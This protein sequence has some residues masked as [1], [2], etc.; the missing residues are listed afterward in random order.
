[1]AN[2]WKFGIL[3][4]GY[5]FSLYLKVLALRNQML[6]CGRP[7]RELP[8]CFYSD[9]PEMENL[10]GAASCG[11]KLRNSKVWTLET[12][13]V[14]Y[15]DKWGHILIQ[16]GATSYDLFTKI[17]I[18]I[19]GYNLPLRGICLRSTIKKLEL[20]CCLWSGCPL[21]KV[22]S[23]KSNIRNITWELK[24]YLFHFVN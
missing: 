5:L 6:G 4:V 10:T 23:K 2:S 11:R 19:E 21:L 22:I 8:F 7:P 14:Q 9:P 16:V 17:V 3:N 18:N 13:I 15:C 20:L 1:M 24:L 12:S